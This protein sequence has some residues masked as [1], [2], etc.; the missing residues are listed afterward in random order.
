MTS[1]PSILSILEGYCAGTRGRGWKVIDSWGHFLHMYAKEVARRLYTFLPTKSLSGA[2]LSLQD[3][4][5]HG[6]G[7]TMPV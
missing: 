6:R 3:S 5:V 2:G 4:N 1:H 7:S